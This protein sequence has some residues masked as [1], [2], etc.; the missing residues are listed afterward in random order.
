MPNSPPT[1]GAIKVVPREHHKQDALTG[2]AWQL[3]QAICTGQFKQGRE[4]NLDLAMVGTHHSGWSEAATQ[5]EEML[6]LWAH[7]DAQV[8]PLR[9]E[10]AVQTGDCRE[11]RN[12]E[13]HLGHERGECCHGCSCAL[14]QGLLEQVAGLQQE[15]ISL[16]ECLRVTDRRGLPAS[17]VARQPSPVS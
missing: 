15:I 14:L 16:R 12:L 1:P 13:A 9:G 10:V 6:P 2:P 8:D 7:V 11:L 4:E 17:A 5:T 3:A